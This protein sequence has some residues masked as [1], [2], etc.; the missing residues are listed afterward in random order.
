MTT[1]TAGR[2]KAYINPDSDTI[3]FTQHHANGSPEKMGEMDFRR[4][5]VEDAIYLLKRLKKI[6]DT[7]AEDSRI[8]RNR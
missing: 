8:R 3:Y 2:L 5:E 7:R 1:L 4:D 6:K